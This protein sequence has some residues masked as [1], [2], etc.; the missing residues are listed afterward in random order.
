[1]ILI[2]NGIL[3]THNKKKPL[4]EDGCVVINGGLI[5]DFGS[6]NEMKEEYPG[7]EFLDA[8]GKIIMPGFINTHM[9]I[10]SEFARGMSIP[11]APISKNFFEILENLWFRIDK[12]LTLEDVKYSA[13]TTYIEC[14]KNGVTTVFDHHASYGAIRNSL[15][16][17]GDV[18]K[19]LGIRTSLCYEVSDRAGKDATKEAIKENIEWIDYTIKEKNDMQ[20][21]MFGLHASFTLSDETLEKCAEA[22][23]GKNIG[24]HVHVAE[25]ISDLQ[26][27]LRKTSKRIVNRFFDFGILGDKTLAIHCIH[28]NPFEM[29][30]LKNTNTAV[31]HNPQSNMGNAVGTSPVLPMMEKGIT[32]GLGTDGYTSDM[33]ESLKV[34]NIIHKHNLCDPSATSDEPLKMLFDNN[35]KIAGRFFNTPLGIIE[36]GAAADIILVEYDSPTPLT[37]DNANFH[38]MFGMSGPKV[39]TVIINGELVMENR[40]IKSVDESEIFAN[41]RKTAKKLWERL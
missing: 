41:A 15:F 7:H 2:G 13:Y 14:I 40:V 37:E 25:G 1:M 20:K 24:Y 6:T 28:I 17:I 9:H 21:G 19:K 18:A 36:K 35:R 4:I 34:A 31:V 38:I 12:A 10:Y 16:T 23:Y 8:K 11:G 22:T 27:T 39:N 29:D 32:V 30:I 33:L 5:E 3:I 26:K